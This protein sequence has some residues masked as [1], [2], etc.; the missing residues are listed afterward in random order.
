[1]EQTIQQQCNTSV[2][3]A[4]KAIAQGYLFSIKDNF[5]SKVTK[6][7]VNT[8]V[9]SICA[10]A[11]STTNMVPH[12]LVWN[13]PKESRNHTVRPKHCCISD[14]DTFIVIIIHFICIALY[15]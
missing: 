10:L 5:V 1:M 14:Q 3:T 15:N 6:E 13:Y 9:F 12:K 4:I 8:T 7:S 11:V 2:I